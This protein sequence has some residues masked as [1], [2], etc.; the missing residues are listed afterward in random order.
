MLRGWHAPRSVHLTLQIMLVSPMHCILHIGTEKTGT[1]LIQKWLYENREA[2]SDEGIALTKTVGAPNNRGLADA[3]SDKIDL[4]LSVRRVSTETELSDYSEQQRRLLRQEL[5]ELGKSHSSVIFTSEQLHSRL[6]TT[7]EIVRLKS[8]LD[9]F[10]DSY[11]VNCYFREQ[12]RVRT[13]LYSTALKSEFGID[14]L[15]FQNDVDLD[16]PY[17]NYVKFF[18]MWEAVFGLSALR[19][20]LYDRQQFEDGDIRKDFLGTVRPNVPVEKL[21][22]ETSVANE[23][24]SVDAGE[25]FKSINSARSVRTGR[26]IDPTPG[27]VKSIVSKL[28]L[29]DQQTPIHDPRQQAMY[30]LFNESNI[31]FFERYFGKAENLFPQPEQ[32]EEGKQK[33]QYGIDTLAEF[34]ATLLHDTNLI[35]MKNDEINFLRDFAD[36]LLDEEKITKEEALKLLKI[37]NRARP[38]GGG[39]RARINRLMKK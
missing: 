6:T 11:Q 12:S 18:G 10:F 14:I 32:R 13:S 20:R 38:N 30:D 33:K 34:A 7:D 3:F 23:S 16:D 35:L 26:F 1:T 39:I 15:H 4:H 24:L 25:L 36:T 37:A 17:Y 19:P 27:F 21:G 22:F 31:V 8:F 29:I 2:L 5:K 9:E 28:T